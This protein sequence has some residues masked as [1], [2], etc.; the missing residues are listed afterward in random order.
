VEGGSGPT[1]RG[2]LFADVVDLPAGTVS[3][4]L[5]AQPDRFAEEFR[6]QAEA[7]MDSIDFTDACG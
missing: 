5:F 4:A 3:F 7:V 2:F 6:V 1:Y